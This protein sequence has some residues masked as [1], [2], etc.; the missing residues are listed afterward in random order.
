MKQQVNETS[1]DLALELVK[2][3]VRRLN[4]AG[5]GPVPKLLKR[6][7]G[8]VGDGPAPETVK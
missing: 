4:E 6:R 5:D 3:Q 2:Q 1:N 8:E 7:V